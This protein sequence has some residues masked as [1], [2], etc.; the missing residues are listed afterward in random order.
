MSAVFEALADMEGTV[1]RVQRGARAVLAL[2]VGLIDMVD[3]DAVAFIGEM[4]ARESTEL[5][6]KWKAAHAAAYDA[7]KAT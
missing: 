6:N 2:A 1:Q 5:F 4:L 7:H 3:A